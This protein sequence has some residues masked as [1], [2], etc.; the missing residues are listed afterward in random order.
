VQVSDV[1]IGYD[2]LRK[3]EAIATFIVDQSRMRSFPRFHFGLSDPVICQKVRRSQ[4][5]ADELEP[6]IKKLK[7]SDQAK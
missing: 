2:F 5:R 6:I 1:A 3:E 7:I 4:L